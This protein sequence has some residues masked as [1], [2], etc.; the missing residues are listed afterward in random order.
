MVF[1]GFY[2]RVGLGVGGGWLNGAIK[3]HINL[4]NQI[5]PSSLTILLNWQAICGFHG[6]DLFHFW[7]Y[8]LYLRVFAC[9][10]WPRDWAVSKSNT[11][12][13]SFTI[14]F[15][16]FE[17]GLPLLAFCSCSAAFWVDVGFFLGGILD[18]GRT[19][20]YKMQELSTFTHVV[21]GGAIKEDYLLFGRDWRALLGTSVAI[22]VVPLAPPYG[23]N[24][25]YIIF[26]TFLISSLADAQTQTITLQIILWNTADWGFFQPFL[27]LSVVVPT[28][29]CDWGFSDR[30]IF[31][32]QTKGIFWKKF[33][34]LSHRP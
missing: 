3:I 28:V 13:S 6:L 26:S 23:S 4:I 27:I 24:P 10:W 29:A 16:F 31:G 15:L 20:N 11:S 14:I 7:C 9:F 17:G 21:K 22:Y 1:H 32:R 30:F 19:Q 12:S 25:T 2:S 18:S 5:I 33:R 34:G 8:I